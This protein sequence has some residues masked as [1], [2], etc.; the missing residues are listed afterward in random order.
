MLTLLFQ[1]NFYLPVSEQENNKGYSDIYLQRRSELYP[2]ITTDWIFELKYVKEEDAD[3]EN[4]IQKQ[5]EKAKRQLLDYKSAVRYK[6]R[7]DIRYVAIVFV[8]K[9]SFLMEEV[10]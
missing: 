4:L 2:K 6:D 3:N 1:S 5:F 8:G 7:K 10:I 9:N